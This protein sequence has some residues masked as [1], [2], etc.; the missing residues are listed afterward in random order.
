MSAVVVADSQSIEAEGHSACPHGAASD[1]G[2][3][4]EAAFDLD[5]PGRAEEAKPRPERN[6]AFNDYL[7][8]F[9]TVSPLQVKPSGYLVAEKRVFKYASKWD[10][11]AYAAGVVASIGAGIT[12]PLI[13]VVFGKTC[14]LACLSN[15]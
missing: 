8:R 10:F 11:L 2:E 14:V 3:E 1:H 12:L 4:R 9:A 7:V 13:N 15:S 5:K 6:A